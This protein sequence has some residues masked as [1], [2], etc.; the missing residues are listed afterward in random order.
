[1]TRFS[2]DW[3]SDV[4]PSD[5]K[6]IE[7]QEDLRLTLHILQHTRQPRRERRESRELLFVEIGLRRA[8]PHAQHP[9]R[10]RLSAVVHSRGGTQRR[11]AERRV[12]KGRKLLGFT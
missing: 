12:G 1:H 2:R 5:L 3:S 7:D 11:S 8:R 10:W 4:C 6:P 9:Q